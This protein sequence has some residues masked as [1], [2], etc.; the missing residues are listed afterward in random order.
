MRLDVRLREWAARR[1]AEGSARYDREETARRAK[2]GP[3]TRLWAWQRF[4]MSLLSLVAMMI[5]GLLAFVA[6]IMLI[7]NDTVGAAWTLLA[8]VLFECVARL[9]AFLHKHMR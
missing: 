2:H 7:A 6:L 4:V 8:S 1:R 9:F 5:G 3:D